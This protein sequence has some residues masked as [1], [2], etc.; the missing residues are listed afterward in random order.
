MPGSFRF[1]SNP[2]QKPRHCCHC[3]HCLF[4]SSGSD[5]KGVLVDGKLSIS[6]QSNG[7]KQDDSQPSLPTPRFGSNFSVSWALGSAG[8]AVT[9][10]AIVAALAI[11]STLVDMVLDSSF[12]N[13]RDRPGKHIDRAV[14]TVLTPLQARTAL[15]ARTALS[16]SQ[17]LRVVTCLHRCFSPGDTQ[18]LR[19]IGDL[20]RV[21]VL[22]HRAGEAE[23]GRKSEEESEIHFGRC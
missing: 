16:L 6:P 23:C 19:D 15:A 9:G 14:A 4:L 17:G 20:S 18:G 10:V 1:S 5:P 13:S 2:K 21:S 8:V 3:I 12:G 22:R 7:S 11:G